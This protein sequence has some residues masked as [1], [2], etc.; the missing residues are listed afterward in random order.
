MPV[1]HGQWLGSTIGQ[2]HAAFAC[3][4]DSCGGG[5]QQGGRGR[6]VPLAGREGGRQERVPVFK[7]VYFVVLSS[8]MPHQLLCAHVQM[9]ACVCHIAVA[10][11]RCDFCF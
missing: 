3:M 2:S 7:N 4:R 10:A 5:W 1:W 11:A 9:F 6:A 8:R